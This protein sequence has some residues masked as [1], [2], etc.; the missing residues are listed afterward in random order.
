MNAQE[1]KQQREAMNPGPPAREGIVYI[2]T[3]HAAAGGCQVWITRAWRY[4]VELPL[5]T[6]LF[7]HSPD[8][9]EWGFGG[10]GPAQLALA[11]LAHAT[12]SDRKALRW[13]Q[14]F[15]R[16]RIAGLERETFGEAWQMSR[17]DILA[18]LAA[19][20]SETVV[21]APFDDPFRPEG[22]E[23][24]ALCAECEGLL[25]NGYCRRCRR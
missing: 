2:G 25:F 22:E 1:R 11:L 3:R 10:S 13:Y 21:T 7:N 19:K 9:V 17:R 6:D 16:E 20:E 8:G 18:W 4:P 23:G 5:R 24:P 12:K 14:A 15:K